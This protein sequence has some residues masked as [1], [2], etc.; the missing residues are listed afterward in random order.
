MSAYSKRIE[1]ND[2]TSTR[3]SESLGT[4]GNLEHMSN[5]AGQIKSS[6]GAVQ[7]ITSP[8]GHLRILNTVT[9]LLRP[10]FFNFSRRKV[11]IITYKKTQLIQST[12][13]VTWTNTHFLKSEFTIDQIDKP[14]NLTRPEFK[15]R[16]P[17]YTAKISWSVGDRTI[18]GS[19][20]V[21]N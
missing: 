9:L 13:T 11:R 19:T 6:V 5:F 4:T 7:C 8:Y 16:P 2:F 21:I 12:V 20:L 17:C 10:L 1:R 18:G 3:W 14:W 15:I